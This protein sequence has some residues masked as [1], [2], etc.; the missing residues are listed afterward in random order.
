MITISVPA[1]VHLLGEHSVVYGKPALLVAID[2]RISITITS[3]KI[4]RIQGIQRYAKEAMR[5][6]E[7]LEKEIKKRIKLK[8]IE[9]YRITIKSE[10]PVGAGLGSSAAL[11]AGLVAALLSFIK[12]PWDNKTIFDIAY[13]GEKF[14]H[15]N[16]SG[17]DLAAVIEGGFLWFRKD[18]KFLKTFSS[19]SFKPHNNIKQFILIDSGK[20]E[21]STREMVEKA[22][23]L[24]MSFPQKV[25]SLFNS[26][27]KL[28]KQ[29]VVALKD[30]NEDSL[31]ECIKLGEKNLEE[32]GVVGKKAQSIIREIEK[33]GGAAKISGGGG[34]KD[35]SG[36]LL[37][38]IKDKNKF[39]NYAKQEK[40]EILLI[41]VGEEGLRK[42]E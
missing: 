1:K 33:L 31:I 27:E 26:Q 17:G 36:M 6:L 40:L 8:K 38:Y 16:P 20:P 37:V 41:E 30:G 21:E 18:F 5:L 11:S 7:I 42:D 15:G 13:T 19:L 9:P 22:A 24:K 35:G 32:L 14:F 2:K 25:E 39:I 10:V 12:I 29:M 23:K 3:S 28:T 34:V 4:K